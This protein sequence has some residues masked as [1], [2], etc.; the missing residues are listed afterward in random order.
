M[1]DGTFEKIGQSD[2]RMYGSKGILVCGYPPS[3]H[4]FF[5]LFMDKAGFNDRP[6][7]FV[8]TED[9]SKSL[10]ELLSLPS[11]WGAGEPSD[12]ARALIVS[13]FTKNELN[14]IMSAYR[15]AGLPGQLWATVTPVS[16]NWTVSR[17]LE[18]LTQ[19]ADSFREKPT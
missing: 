14:R 16:E 19:E 11:T 4:K 6:V 18:E 12:M 15:W 5:V 3:E 7:I 9:A 1:E 13:G 8:R 2:E 10:K 17:L